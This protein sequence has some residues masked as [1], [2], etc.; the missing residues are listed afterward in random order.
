[1]S[2]GS[3]FARL[4]LKNAAQRTGQFFKLMSGA[5]VMIIFDRSIARSIGRSIARSLGRS[6]ARSLDRSIARSLGRSVARSLGLDYP[7]QPGLFLLV[8]RPGFYYPARILNNPKYSNLQFFVE[9]EILQIVLQF[10]TVEIYSFKTVDFTSQGIQDFKFE[11]KR[12][13]CRVFTEAS[14]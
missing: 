9:A 3:T 12:L 11:Y 6:V 10:K 5:R 2:I 13:A 1:M 7:A 4:V 8:T 14:G